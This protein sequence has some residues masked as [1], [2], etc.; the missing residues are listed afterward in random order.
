MVGLC[1]DPT[2]LKTARSG[3]P[4]GCVGR[5][6]YLLLLWGGVGLGAGDGEGGEE[7]GDIEEVELAVVGEVGAVVF[8]CEVGEEV[9][10]IEE[11]LCVVVVDVCGAG[12]EGCAEGEVVY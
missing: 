2:A 1:E 11:V 6:L 5:G 9:G 12:E 7:G 4:E 10:D 3:H 8:V